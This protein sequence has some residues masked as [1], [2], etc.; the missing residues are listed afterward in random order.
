MSENIGTLVEQW[1]DMGPLAW[2][3][4]PFGWVME[5]GRPIILAPWQRAI[6]AA[7]WERRATVTPLGISNA[8]KTGKTLLDALLLAWR[9]LVLPGE[10]FSCGNDEDQAGTRQF[11]M[12]AEMVKRHPV[13][14]EYVRATQRQLIFMPTGST[15]T[16]LAVDAAGNAGSN[17][18]TASHTETWGILYEAGI[19]AWEELTPP[20][21]RRY[22]LPPLRIADSY[23]GWLAESETWHN[24]VDKGLAG[25]RIPGDWP[26]FE[27]GGL[28][29][30]HM[31]G[32]EAQRRCFLGTPEEARVYYR[33]QEGSL[34][35]NAYKR[36]HLNLR[37]S[38]ESQFA[39]VAW[40]DRAAVGAPI[41][42]NPALDVVLGVD[43]GLKRDSAAVTACTHDDSTGRVVLVNHRIF[44][45]TK[46]ETLDLEDTLEA[47]VLDFA[48][49]FRLRA[50]RFD[51]WQFQRSA[52]ALTK[53][54]LPMV[55]FAQTVPNLTSMSM[56]LF[57]LLKAEN[58][59]A[60]A[61]DEIRLALQRCVI[62]EGSRGM[63]IAKERGGHRIDVIVS[64]AM[65]ALGAVELLAHRG[66][67]QLHVMAN[68][69]YGGS[70]EAMHAEAAGQGG[71]TSPAEGDK[72]E[73][74]SDNTLILRRHENP[75]TSWRTC[76]YFQRGLHGGKYDCRVCRP[77]FWTYIHKPREERELEDAAWE[78][79]RQQEKK[80]LRP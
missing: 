46:G 38:G 13:L 4:H 27:N 39:P 66:D 11:A 52:Q 53:K 80:G 1:R 48:Q 10:H 58:L 79:Q 68:P 51:P 24:L 25:R 7:W 34:R 22:G 62:V 32:E 64:L 71:D 69:F 45:P 29:L 17:H 31:D 20:P 57:E 2:A 50:V 59:V 15:I 73:T 40:W 26:I 42:S 75:S 5:G 76:Y 44:Y 19:R 60:Y 12:I 61:D 35:P 18:M 55:E 78:L 14:S 72:F 3:E 23:A 28:L 49:R 41:A 54:G 9:C 70:L 67:G 65:A 30:F 8:K 16:A 56:N 36:M 21:G 63:K 47:A 74:R 43:A 33:D 77:T 37:T 6:L